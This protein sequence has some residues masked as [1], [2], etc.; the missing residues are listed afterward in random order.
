MVLAGDD[1]GLEVFI[2]HPGRPVAHRQ[3]ELG[4][5]GMPDQG[6]HR[7]VVACRHPQQLSSWL[8]LC[9]GSRPHDGVLIL[10]NFAELGLGACTQALLEAKG[11]Q[12]QL[13]C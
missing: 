10:L 11:G 9:C 3:E 13:F 4:V 2:P 7:P 5:E 8:M 12:M 1:G 6:I